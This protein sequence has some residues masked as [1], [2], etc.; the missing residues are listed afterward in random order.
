MYCSICSTAEAEYDKVRGAAGAEYDKVR[1]AHG[2]H[3]YPVPE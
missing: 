3:P 1:G 2:D